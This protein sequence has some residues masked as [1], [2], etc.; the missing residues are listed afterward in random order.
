MGFLVLAAGGLACESEPGEESSSTGG[1]E[2]GSAGTGASVAI[3]GM[4]GTG[5]TTPPVGGGTTSGAPP[6]TGGASGTLTG[7]TGGIATT[8]GMGAGGTGGDTTDSIRWYPGAGIYRDVWLVTTDPVHVAQWG[9]YLRTPQVSAGSATVELDVTVDNDSAQDVTASVATD[10]YEVDAGGNRVGAAVASIA[11]A[12]LSITAGASATAATRSSIANPRLWGVPPVGV[13]NL[14]E[15]VTTVTVDRTVV[16]D[17]RTRF[18]V[19]T[20]TYDPNQGFLLN[21]DYLKIK[22]VC[23][24]H[25][26]GA[27]GSVANVRGKERQLE[28]L[29]EMGSN[30]IRTKHGQR[31]PSKS[32]RCS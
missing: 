4:P 23:N 17:Y 29:A 18:G 15:A 30:A 27:L 6:L 31:R 8:G 10:I 11:A 16:D 21:G 22:G 12:Y 1:I 24:H 14:Y 5:G 9:T 13:P 2:A 7:G 32:R 25:D 20:F 3:G 28:I 26:L 19:R